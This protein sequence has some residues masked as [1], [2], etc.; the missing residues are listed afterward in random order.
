MYFMGIL[1]ILG[2]IMQSNAFS[3][4]LAYI[5]SRKTN[6]QEVVLDCGIFFYDYVEK[7]LKNTFK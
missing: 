7:S 6:M 4:T 1:G 2:I 5:A 3:V